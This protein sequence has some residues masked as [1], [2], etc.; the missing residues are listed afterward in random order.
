MAEYA[1]STTGVA[2]TEAVR[3]ANNTTANA[4][5]L[6][7]RIMRE[8]GIDEVA[9]E[10]REVP[11]VGNDSFSGSTGKKVSSVLRSLPI[12]RADASEVPGVRLVED[13]DEYYVKRPLVPA[14]LGGIAYTRTASSVF[15]SE[16]ISD[17]QSEGVS[18]MPVEERPRVYDGEVGM[19]ATVENIERSQQTAHAFMAHLVDILQGST[20]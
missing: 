2:K 7:R 4:V 13:R 3:H 9:S 10:R 11:L 20:L 16:V 17:P 15:Y 5:H 6:S 1:K 12:P 18:T 8:V 19:A 14:F